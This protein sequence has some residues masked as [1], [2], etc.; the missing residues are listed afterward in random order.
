MERKL[1]IGDNAI[2]GVKV[3]VVRKRG[4]R[5]NLRVLPD[6]TVRLMVPHWR[7]TLAQGAAFLAENWAWAMRMRER[8]LANPPPRPT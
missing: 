7:A 3:T 2:D 8:A 1:K 6:G 4:K 5:I